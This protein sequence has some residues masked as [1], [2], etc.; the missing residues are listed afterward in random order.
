MSLGVTTAFHLHDMDQ[1]NLRFL[2]MTVATESVDSRGAWRYLGWSQASYIRIWTKDMLVSSF[3]MVLLFWRQEPE[4]GVLL[5]ELS[6]GPH[7]MRQDGELE[8]LLMSTPVR[9]CRQEGSL[10]KKWPNCFFQIRT[11]AKIYEASIGHPHPYYADHRGTSRIKSY[12]RLLVTFRNL[13]PHNHRTLNLLSRVIRAAP[14]HVTSNRD[15]R[16]SEPVPLAD[17]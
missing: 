13:K 12:K 9:Y 6:E 10:K 1:M 14:G 5:P 17:P 16:A 8:P 11:E 3:L 7:V 4:Y 2:Q 15:R